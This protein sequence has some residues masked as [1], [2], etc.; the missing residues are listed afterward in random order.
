VETD[1][2]ELKEFLSRTPFFGGVD[3]AALDQLA[4]LLIARDFALGETVFS[5]GDHGRSM[6][7]VRTGEVVALQRSE[8]APVKLMRFRPGDFFGE[9]TLIE[10][11]P[12][13]FSAVAEQPSQVLELKSLHLYALYQRDVHAYVMV[14]QNINRELCRRLRRASQRL[15]YLAAEFA[16]DETQ[17]P[18][19]YAR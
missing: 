5:E 12:R 15:S 11:Q 2:A 10:M 1:L 9:T 13:P 8:T 3:D 17:M 4:R 18:D 19:E 7:I 16:D 14:L 6:F